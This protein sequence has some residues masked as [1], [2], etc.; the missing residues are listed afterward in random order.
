MQ[1]ALLSTAE[2]PADSCRR[3]HLSPTPVEIFAKGGGRMAFG[4]HWFSECP[5]DGLVKMDRLG[6]CRLRGDLARC[7]MPIC[8]SPCT[9]ALHAKRLFL[10]KAGPGLRLASLGL[11]RRP[12]YEG[13]GESVYDGADGQE[14]AGK[15]LHRGWP[16]CA[17]HLHFSSRRLEEAK[18]YWH[19]RG[20]P[21]VRVLRQ[22]LIAAM[23]SWA[24]A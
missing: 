23:I 1:S 14:K 15:S 5:G 20:T 13:K 19:G 22:M 9:S 4:E 11:H 2:L 3:S 6:V 8:M 12:S 24:P 10:T 17:G 18:S 7:A 21:P 16:V